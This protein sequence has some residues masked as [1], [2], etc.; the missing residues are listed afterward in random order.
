MT[1][2]VWAPAE[3]AGTTKV[4]ETAPAAD[5]A[6]PPDVQ[7]EIE[8]V[9]NLIVTELLTVNPVPVTVTELPTGPWVGD[10]APS[11]G[12]VTVYAVVGADPEP[13]SVTVIV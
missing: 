5:V 10:A 1:V 3:E 13:V 11:V 12:T 7:V 8:V 9:A 4:Q 2:I 6:N